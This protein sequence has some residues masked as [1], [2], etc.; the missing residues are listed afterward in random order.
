MVDGRGAEARALLEQLGERNPSRETY[1]FAA[2]TLEYLGDRR[3]AEDWKRR[4]AAFPGRAN[5]P[6]CAG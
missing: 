4:A 5:R 3:T 6:D 2:K 1:L